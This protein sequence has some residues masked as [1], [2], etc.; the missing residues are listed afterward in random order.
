MGTQKNCFNKM[1]V[2]QKY[3]RFYAQNFCFTV[4]INGSV[5]TYV[6]GAQMSSLV[7]I[8]LEYPEHMFWL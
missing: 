3:S 7:E 6:L 1:L 8:V 2:I 5:K 4:A